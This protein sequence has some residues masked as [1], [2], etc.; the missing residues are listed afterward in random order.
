MAPCALEQDAGA[1]PAQLG[2]ALPHR[3]GVRQQLRRQRVQLGEQ[4]R[5]I[6]RLVAERAPQRIV[7][8]QQLVDPAREQVGRRQIA[9][10]DRPAR[11]L[12]LVGRADAPAGRADRAGAGAAGGAPARAP[13]E[14]AVQRQDER[15]G[16]GDAQIVRPDR[17]AAA[18][19]VSISSSSAQGSI[20]TPLPRIDSLPGRTAG[21]QQA[22]LVGL[23][24]DHQGV[25]GVVP[26]LE[27][28]H[29][30]G[31][32]ESQSTILPLP[33]S[34]HWAPT[35]ATLVMSRSRSPGADRLRGGIA[36]HEMPAAVKSARAARSEPQHLALDVRQRA[37][38]HEQPLGQRLVDQDQRDRL[39]AGA[40][41]A[42]MEGR[43]VDPA[44]P[45]VL[46]SAPMMPG[47]S[48]LRT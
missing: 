35:T 42:Q 22:E 45:S 4:R 27:A 48:S 16:L 29:D 36:Q 3:L 32:S 46:P 5:R 43:D 17:D 19:S 18:R 44:S 23:A 12:V 40:G 25:A 7:M 47:L 28:D 39:A 13:V 37:D 34:P 11:D 30:L 15:R 20:T 24:V 26:A 41:A 9:H 8:Q 33:S 31:A 14:L 2:Q 10:P 1:A 38:R 6:D 21:R